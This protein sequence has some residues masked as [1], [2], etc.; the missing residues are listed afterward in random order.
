MVTPLR[1]AGGGEGSGA[2][3]Y[4]RYMA[5]FIGLTEADVD[6][7]RRTRPILEKHLPDV[8]ARFYAHLLR[9]PPTRRVFSRA[10]GS[11]DHDYLEL[12]M[13]HQHNFWLRTAEGV[14]D[15]DYAEYVAYVSRAHTSR[16]ADPDIYIPERYVIG[17]VGFVQHAFTQA[18]TQELAHDEELE[19]AAVSAWNKLLMVI[20]EVLASAYRHEHAAE[21]YEAFQ[22]VDEAAMS[23]LAQRAFDREQGPVVPVPLRE[24]RVTAANELP[25]GERKIVE[26]DGVS[27]GVFHH[28]GEWHAVRNYCL[29]RGGPVATGTLDGDVL[30]CPWHGFQYDVTTGRSL[31]DPLAEL[32][33]YGVIERDG[34]IYVQVPDQ[35]PAAAAPP[36]P[37][38]AA[39]ASFLGENEFR[40]AEVAPGSFKLVELDG[41]GVLV[42]NVGGVF[43][44]TQAE[45][46]HAYGPLEEGTLDGHLIVCPL[47]DSRFDVTSG[48]VV[49]GPARD[50]L[51]TFRV[52]IDAGVGRVEAITL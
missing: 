7:I 24:V 13:R 4:F 49:A 2:G 33:V 35:V 45:C 22:P 20:L 11:I 43:H 44:A 34:E 38:P 17:M 27:I 40:P 39:P 48:Q 30:T 46:P 12:R 41:E 29:H 16:G 47:H 5:E 8:V 6:V 52:V 50:P 32:D 42:Y 19:D 37:A 51:R 10:D 28:R 36:A 25:D 21:A 15:D 3:R 23:A 26:V 31:V 1:Q 14:Y 18:L 9:Y